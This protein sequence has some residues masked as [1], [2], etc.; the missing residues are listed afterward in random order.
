M[1]R[2]IRA[3]LIAMMMG[4]SVAGLSILGSAYVIHD[5][6]SYKQT[7]AAKLEILA[8]VIADRSVAAILF[9]DEEVIRENLYSLMASEEIMD[10]VVF[11]PDRS[12]LS[13]YVRDN[14]D[15]VDAAFPEWD[16]S[17]FIDDTIVTA[18]PVIMEHE[19]IATL[20]IR[21]HLHELDARLN[22]FLQLSLLLIALVAL[23]S[24]LLAIKLQSIISNPILSLT[25][26]AQKVH[27][28]EDYSLRPLKRSNDEVGILSDAFSQMLSTIEEKNRALQSSLNRTLHLNEKIIQT[29]PTPFFYIDRDLK[30]RKVNQAFSTMMGVQSDDVLGRKD[31]E[32]WPDAFGK[33]HEDIQKQTMQEQHRMFETVIEDSNGNSKDVIYYK[34]V[35]YD[36]N[37]AFDGIIGIMIDISE[38]K[39]I[40]AA[41]HKAKESAEAANRAKSEFLANMSHE[42]RT[43]MN[44]ILGFTELLEE[45]IK[46][47][48]LQS[49]VKTIHSAG[50]TLLMLI[51]DV[52][53]LSKIEAGKMKVEKTPVNM[54]ELLVEV[55]NVFTMNIRN[56]GLDLVIDIDSSIPTSVLLDGV[57]I[58]QILFNLIGNAVKFTEEGY[59]RLKA[60]KA[61]E[62]TS[63]SKI[64]LLL[65]VEDTGV[66]IP[67][68][69]QDTIFNLFEQ[70]EGQSTRK[71]G[72]TGLGLAISKRLTEMMDGEISVEST[73]GEGT[74]FT[75]KLHDV[76][77]A[78]VEAEN[79]DKKQQFNP[80]AIR[81]EE[82]VVLIV[83]DVENNR[84]LVKENFVSTPIRYFEA[85]N[86]IEAVNMM[87]EHAIDLVLMDIR[88][89]EM[90]GYTAAREIR[91]FSDVPIVALT[92]SVMEDEYERSKREHFMGYL[93]KPVLRS[94]LFEM[95]ARFLPH[96]TLH[97]TSQS[98]EEITLTEPALEA[99]PQ[100]LEVLDGP[101]SAQLA[102]ARERNNFSDIEAFAKEVAKVAETYDV[103]VLREYA[104]ELFELI[105][106]FDIGGI[107]L[108]L[109]A[110]DTLLAA[111]H[112]LKQ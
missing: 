76:D 63:E 104:A 84:K 26:L 17:R 95:L 72:G 14:S 110:F 6:Y 73:Y 107:S 87:K 71:Y 101:V 67:A 69:Q 103:A 74:C 11:A 2:N 34:E 48:R 78:S 18:I 25:Q 8:Q 102:L 20:M 79:E 37:D 7:I 12:V 112:A 109:K 70:Q 47:P 58:R 61:N 75:L 53:D 4:L 46:E 100:I 91:S 94:E 32:L 35:L 27:Q 5:R 1:L 98:K 39:E 50:N 28:E 54:H 38:R 9:N 36:D 56:K 64:D 93:R 55:G 44:A 43:P 83:D 92:A 68:D 82:A 3:K 57:R 41:L 49:F 96:T 77:V 59:V 16:G 23:L 24:Y 29:L 21:G 22:Q 65:S 51:N 62:R 40:E 31:E 13:H 99:L 86:G 89:P 85:A 80:H 60:Q 33:I 19:Q 52:L 108:K 45:Q 88:M 105:G 111:L 81:F 10:A 66:G 106:A 42:I 90:D 30:Y 15:L 97:E